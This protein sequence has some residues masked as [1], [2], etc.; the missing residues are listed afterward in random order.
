M[1][2]FTV[3]FHPDNIAVTDCDQPGVLL[4]LRQICTSD[5]D[6]MTLFVA[7]DSMDA[8]FVSQAYT[9]NHGEHQ[10]IQG[11]TPTVRNCPAFRSGILP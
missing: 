9:G 5:T 2:L 3:I 10:Q 7:L 8:S 11:D 1:V 6:K 4:T